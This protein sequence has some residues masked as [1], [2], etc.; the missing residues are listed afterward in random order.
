ML[1]IIIKKLIIKY[2]EKTNKN[3][4]ICKYCFIKDLNIRFNETE[5]VNININ[6]IDDKY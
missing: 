6:K 1:E 3:L 5:H 4:Y 2:K